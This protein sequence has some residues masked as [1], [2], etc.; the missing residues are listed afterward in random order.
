MISSHV[1]YVGFFFLSLARIK[2]NLTNFI[3]LNFVAYGISRKNHLGWQSSRSRPLT[4]ILRRFFFFNGSKNCK[5]SL[6]VKLNM[7]GTNLPS[8]P[9]F[10]TFLILYRSRAFFL[11]Y[12]FTYLHNSQN[13]SVICYRFFN[14]ALF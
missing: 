3:V 13:I 2:K 14:F 12:S 9:T 8:F 1:F 6:Y 11:W 10:S 4:K 7:A 5:L